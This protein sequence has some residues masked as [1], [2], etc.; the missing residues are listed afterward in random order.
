VIV[1]SVASNT[2]KM[3]IVGVPGSE[4]L[5]SGAAEAGGDDG[6]IDS[7]AVA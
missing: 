4:V 2:C 5:R 1:V 7:A 6:S 3:G